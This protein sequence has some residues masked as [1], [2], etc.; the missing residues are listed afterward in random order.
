MLSAASKLAKQSATVLAPRPRFNGAAFALAVAS[1]Q[2][3]GMAA[4]APH[5]VHYLN[6]REAQQLDEQLMS[7]PGFSVH[8]L[9]ELAGLSV[10]TAVHS[11]FPPEDFPRVLVVCGPGNNGGDG[12]VA[13]R[14]LHMFGYETVRQ[15][16]MALRILRLTRL[17]RVHPPPCTGVR[18]IP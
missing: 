17:Q 8:A 6:Q 1:L 3:L 5:P 2:T 16:L 9:M 18:C 7:S 11:A 4:G 14:H 15:S 12:L 10:A 13:A